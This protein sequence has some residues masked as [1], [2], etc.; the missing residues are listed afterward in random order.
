MKKI[1]LKKLPW[2]SL[3]RKIDKLPP[4]LDEEG[5]AIPTQIPEF[6]YQEQAIEFI[7]QPSDADKG[8]KRKEMKAMRSL[9]NKLDEAEFGDATEMEIL[10]EDAEHA[11]LVE[12]ASNMAYKE[13]FP[14]VDLMLDELCEEVDVPVAE[15]KE[16]KEA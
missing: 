3:K 9:Y 13:Y 1:T 11:I 8:M 6:D 14:E 10:L 16:L 7:S 2:A 5:N 12:K 4:Q 15:V